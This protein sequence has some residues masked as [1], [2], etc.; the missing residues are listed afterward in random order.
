[1]RETNSKLLA[2]V[3]VSENRAVPAHAQEDRSHLVAALTEIDA[4]RILTFWSWLVDRPVTI[5]E[6]TRFGDWFLA[7]A[8]GQVYRLDIL[9]GTFAP[10]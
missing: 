9:E 7:D 3:L 2:V 6:L 8:D 10:V 1:L 4:P 5:L